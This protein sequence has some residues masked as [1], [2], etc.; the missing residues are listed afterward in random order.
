ME[1]LIEQV[2]TILNGS[3][4]RSMPLSHLLRALSASGVCLDGR[5]DW[6]IQRL[7]QNTE[8]FRII[9]DRLG[10]WIHWPDRLGAAPPIQGPPGDPWIIAGPYPT[11]VSVTSQGILDRLRDTLT[12]WG[13]EVDDGSQVRIARWLQANREAELALKKLLNPPGN[14][15]RTR[16]STTHPPGPPLRRRTHGE[17]PLAG[18]R[19][20]GHPGRH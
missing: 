9:P 5:A 11:N 3:P 13:W 16:R 17:R 4:T 15:I 20:A 10:P 6:L 18:S 2:K 12:A 8:L 19:P 1:L 14:P 7:M